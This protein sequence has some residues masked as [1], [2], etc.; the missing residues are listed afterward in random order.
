MDR[1][2]AAHEPP[3]ARYAG[4]KNFVTTFTTISKEVARIMEITVPLHEF[5]LQ[6]I[7]SPLHSTSLA[8]KVYCDAL[9]TDVLL[10]SSSIEHAIGAKNDEIRALSDFFQVN[11]RSAFFGPPKNECEVQDNI[12]RLLIGKGLVRGVDY[13]REKGRVAVSI[14]ETVPD[15]I[16]HR[17]SLAIEAKLSRNKT[18]SRKIVDQINADIQA[19]GKAYSSIV[20]IVYDLGSIQNEVEF[21]RGLES[22]ETSVYIVIVKQ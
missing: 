5:D 15:F 18:E 2:V 12:E 4:L 16:V 8:Q 13:E 1:S 11:L 9:F 7:P 21:K 20:F 10:L 22:A 14:K 17:L 19:Y 3:I 6:S